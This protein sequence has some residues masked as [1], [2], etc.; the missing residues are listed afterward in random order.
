MLKQQCLE[1]Q[2]GSFTQRQLLHGKR[3]I[4]KRQCPLM[5]K[6]LSLSIILVVQKSMEE[7][8]VIKISTVIYKNNKKL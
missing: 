6:T 5:A 2:K 3:N 4:M 7:K 8:K 1:F